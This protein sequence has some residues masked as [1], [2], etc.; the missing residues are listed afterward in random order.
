[1]SRSASPRESCS[2][3]ERS[4]TAW[5]PS[6]WTPT[7]NDTRV[8]VEGFSKISATL[9]PGQRRR[10]QRRPLE[11]ERAVEQRVELRCAQLGSG[12]EMARRHEAVSLGLRVRPPGS[13]RGGRARPWGARGPPIVRRSS[14]EAS[15]SRKDR[16]PMNRR[17]ALLACSALA[18]ALGAL[19]A[20]CGSS[21]SS[22]STSS[23]SSSA[24]HGAGGQPES[25]H[26]AAVRHAV[27]L[28]AGAE[29]DR[30]D[31]LPQHRDQPGHAAG[32]G[33]QHDQVDQ[34]RLR[35]TQRHQRGRAAAVRLEG[36]RRRRHIRDQ[37]H[38]ARGRSTT[39]A[40]STRPR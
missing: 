32:E 38:Q 33:G 24:E 12:E 25:D 11:L 5:P 30:P 7:S 28:G 37:G 3:S 19:A 1:M 20:G 8:R 2:S 21:S 23:A 14:A 39:S 17:I 35:R 15:P 6:S 40:R 27:G 10:G 26:D 18:C 31:R 34:L 16:P 13:P 29:R 4:T 36:L 9:R 22:S